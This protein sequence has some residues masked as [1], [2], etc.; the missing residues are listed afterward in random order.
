MKE[1]NEQK[2]KMIYDYNNNIDN[3]EKNMFENYHT[4]VNL[5]SLL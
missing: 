5:K 3:D 2:E 1:N 4:L